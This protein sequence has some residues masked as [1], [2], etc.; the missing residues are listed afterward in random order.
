MNAITIFLFVVLCGYS[1]LSCFGFRHRRGGGF[2]H[3]L[4]ISILISLACY[5]Y[6]IAG[7]TFPLSGEQYAGLCGLTLSIALLAW[8]IR[9]HR[10]RPGAAFAGYL[11]GT[12]IRHGPYRI[13][14]HPIYLSYLL[15]LLSGVAIIARAEL[16]VIPIWM[17]FLYH[18]AARQEENQILSSPLRESYLEYA[19][20]AGRFLPRL[21]TCLGSGDRGS[22]AA[23]P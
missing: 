19:R 5:A 1:C 21:T 17:L 13:V 22:A 2:Q 7:I 20:Q 8:A 10:S 4:L 16:L 18:I 6:Q 9:C 15:A 14:R 3:I 12:L 11:P 23:K